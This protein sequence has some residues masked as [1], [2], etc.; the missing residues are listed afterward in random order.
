MSTAIEGGS[1]SW[2]DR[3]RMCDKDGR[4][5]NA[6]NPKNFNSGNPYYGDPAYYSNSDNYILVKVDDEYI[7]IG[8]EQF[9]TALQLLSKSELYAEE[10]LEFVSTGDYDDELADAFF[11]LA[12]FGDIVYG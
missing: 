1:V 12:T 8:Q 10:Y 3:I 4:V 6:L 11:Q 7:V 2:C 5:N 9:N